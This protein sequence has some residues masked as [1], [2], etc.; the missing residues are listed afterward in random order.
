MLLSPCS[1]SVK[2]AVNMLQAYPVAQ[3]LLVL[4]LLCKLAP[5]LHNCLICSADRVR[6]SFRVW[7]VGYETVACFLAFCL[8]YLMVKYP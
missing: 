7:G 6:H 5:A 2:C 8:P 3:S 1:E 4:Q